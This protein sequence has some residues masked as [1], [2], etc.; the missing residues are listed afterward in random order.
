LLF[1]YRS[2]QWTR[3]DS[4][5]SCIRG[6]PLGLDAAG[7]PIL[8]LRTSH[9]FTTT[10]QGVYRLVDGQ[11]RDI[12]LGLEKNTEKLATR[13]FRDSRGREYFSLKNQGDVPTCAGFVRLGEDILERWETFEFN[14]DPLGTSILR[15]P[16]CANDFEASGDTVFLASSPGLA[17][18]VD[19]AITYIRNF[20]G[21]AARS[22]SDVLPMR[23]FSGKATLHR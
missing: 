12:P 16:I 11:C 20:G 19:T 10:S 3:Y 17:V 14:R 21:V 1:R 8:E 22:A 13:Y 2:G 5:L 23:S 4:S 6:V 9:I 15:M 7:N 18:L